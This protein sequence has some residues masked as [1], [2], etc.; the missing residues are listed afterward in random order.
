MADAAAAA[1]AG[2]SRTKEPKKRK[3]VAF[4]SESE[5]PPAKKSADK[6]KNKSKSPGKGQAVLRL[7]PSYQDGQYAAALT[8]SAGFSLPNGISYSAEVASLTKKKPRPGEES[9]LYLSG[10]DDI[11]FFHNT[12]W[13]PQPLN[14]EGRRPPA[15]KGYSGQYLVGVHDPETS[16]ITLHRAPLFTMTRVI[17]NLQN[18]AS[19]KADTL[20]QSADWNAR[21]A[22]RR[23]LGDVF[24]T[25]K[26]KASVRAQDRLKVDASH[27]GAMLDEVAE[28]ITQSA[29]VLPSVA[30][31]TETEASGRPG[32]VPNM[33]ATEPAE[34]YPPRILVP[35][36][37]FDTLPISRLIASE[38]ED[39]L[40]KTLPQ[41]CIRS[42]WLISRMWTLIK[43]IQTN[44]SQGEGGILRTTKEESRTKLRLALYL[45]LLWGFIK[46]RTLLD[47]KSTLMGRL[48]ISSAPN[49]EMIVDDLITRFAETPRGGGKPMLTAARETKLYTHICALALH[50]EDFAISVSDLAQ[51][52]GLPNN[53]LADYFKA[54]GCSS[55]DVDVPVPTPSSNALESSTSS[56]RKER[57]MVLKLPLKF[58]QVR[59]RAPP[60]SR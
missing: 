60:K 14:Q 6:S 46:A 3:S 11:I 53:K 39:A 50:L 12:N 31:I 59:K 51:A 5:L 55:G 45:A 30:D 58:P 40:K 18:L 26:A 28:G 19:I 29:A 52:L 33:L 8:S 36:A 37:I 32:P 54:I 24:G 41:A 35:A 57:R 20:G 1:A 9:A 4:D 56:V 10:Q 27:M 22:A 21:V 48:R 7:A 25:R 43:R 47:D 49:A 17:T 42:E 16:T 2:P 23:D 38:D 44:T 15:D 34:V 13:R